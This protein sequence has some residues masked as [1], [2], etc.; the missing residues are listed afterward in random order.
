MTRS[1]YRLFSVD[2]FHIEIAGRCI[3]EAWC[4]SML[5]TAGCMPRWYYVVRERDGSTVR[6]EEPF[7]LPLNLVTSTHVLNKSIHPVYLR[8]AIIRPA[9][10]S[11]NLAL[12]S[13]DFNRV[14]YFSRYS[15]RRRISLIAPV[16]HAV[17]RGITFCSF[18]AT[19]RLECCR[20]QF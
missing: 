16:I 13:S 17:T 14:R 7:T 8:C 1:R 15:Q 4:V 19:K 9:M 5:S 12:S 18:A 10:V 3:V 20:W 2:C 11:E 6:T